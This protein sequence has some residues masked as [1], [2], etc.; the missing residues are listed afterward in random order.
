MKKS[1]FTIFCYCLSAPVFLLLAACQST[2][3]Q[4]TSAASPAPAPAA[5][6]APAKPSA[7]RQPFDVLANFVASGWMEDCQ[8]GPP[9]CEWNPSST[10][11][12]HSPPLCVRVSYR[13]GRAGWGGIYLQHP[14]DNWGTQQGRNLS[15]YRR[16]TFWARADNPTF[17][18]FKTGGIDKPGSPYRDSYEASL[19]MQSLTTDW[20]Q[21]TIN[22]ENA[23]L[24]SVIG[25]FVWVATK[26]ANPNG[27]TFYLDDINF[28]N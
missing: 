5:Q 27:V 13:P 28:E 20:R 1:R 21:Y 16:L 14:A 7:S 4:G 11:N 23:N 22:L 9:A 12:P 6:E 26:T 18:E 3:T 2:P 19:G 15:G 17:V 10:V 24:S 8:S 25:G